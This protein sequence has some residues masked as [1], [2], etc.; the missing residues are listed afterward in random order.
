L[1]SLAPAS[2]AA[3]EASARERARLLGIA[4][5]GRE[6]LAKRDQLRKH[7][8]TENSAAHAAKEARDD[9]LA[10]LLQ[11]RQA[12]EVASAAMNAALSSLKLRL[13]AEESKCRAAEESQQRL[14]HTLLGEEATVASLEAAGS[15]ASMATQEAAT[16]RPLTTHTLRGHAVETAL[17][18]SRRDHFEMGAVFL[19]S[20]V[21]RRKRDEEGST[22]F[23]KTVR[24][25]ER[26]AYADAAAEEH[27]H[28]DVAQ[29]LERSA[30]VPPRERKLP[31]ER[32]SPGD[33]DLLLELEASRRAR[34][35]R[36]HGVLQGESHAEEQGPEWA[37]ARLR[38]LEA[39]ALLTAPTAPYPSS[40]RGRVGAPR[41]E[42]LLGP[43]PARTEGLARLAERVVHH[44]HHCDD[45]QE[46]AVET[47]GEAMFLQPDG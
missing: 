16:R 32:E 25:E 8:A 10:E 9:A 1:L 37:S 42:V 12:M 47:E 15:L 13:A 40:A 30:G 46:D 31:R 6:A 34:S 35:A 21:A 7:A 23:P 22:A 18:K 17:T 20:A 26:H 14:E 44:D 43:V 5:E 24:G 29:T 36:R 28:E 27:E 4:Q 3:E 38:E 2:A 11:E 33:V 19:D 41:A 39:Q 45:S